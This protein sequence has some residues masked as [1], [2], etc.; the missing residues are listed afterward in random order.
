ML[1]EKYPSSTKMHQ[2]PAGSTPYT[3]AGYTL[4]SR[5][6]HGPESHFFVRPFT[7]G[8]AGFQTRNAELSTEK[9]KDLASGK[10][11]YADDNTW[12]TQYK[13]QGDNQFLASY[14]N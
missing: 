9:V 10:Y 5:G 8:Y 11:Y 14:T 7:S 1:K 3:S 2:T 6:T 13:A 12:A 4:P